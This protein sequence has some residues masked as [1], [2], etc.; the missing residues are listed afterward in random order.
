M[1]SQGVR[2]KEVEG[3]GNTYGNQK[4]EK[5]SN[6]HIKSNKVVHLNKY[7]M[8]IKAENKVPAKVRPSSH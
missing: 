6:N 3:F 1:E 8:F 5:I 4:G 7:S 2:E